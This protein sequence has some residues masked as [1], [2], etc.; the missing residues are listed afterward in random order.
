MLATL[1]VLSSMTATACAGGD[2]A[3]E[4]ASTPSPTLDTPTAPDGTVPPPVTH[5]PAATAGPVLEWAPIWDASERV[6]VGLPAGAEAFESTVT[7]NDGSEIAVTGYA[8]SDDEGAIAFEI[9]T[10]PSPRD[11]VEW[12]LDMLLEQGGVD[13]ENSTVRPVEVGG[14]AGVD[15]ELVLGDGVLM[16][17]RVLPLDGDHEVLV[18]DTIGPSTERER[19]ESEFARL[20]IGTFFA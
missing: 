8:V 11:G 5:S 18:V 12:Y 17:L 16:L 9:A 2:G 15:A 4:A 10:A 3:A 7:L 13:I 1:V 6:S 14:R 20:T 19:L